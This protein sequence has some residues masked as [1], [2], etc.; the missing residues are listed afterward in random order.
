[1][2]LRGLLTYLDLD[3]LDIKS[4]GFYLQPILGFENVR[5]A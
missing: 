3:Y 2:Y 5:T 4:V 1:M